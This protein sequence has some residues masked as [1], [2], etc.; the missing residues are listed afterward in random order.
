MDYLGNPFGPMPNLM[1][2]SS[3]LQKYMPFVKNQEILQI[4]VTEKTTKRYR[5]YRRKRQI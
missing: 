2:I 5:C 3:M 1:A 4:I